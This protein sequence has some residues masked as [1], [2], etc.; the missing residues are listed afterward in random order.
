MQR[1]KNAAGIQNSYVAKMQQKLVGPNI[2]VL[3][4]LKAAAGG[5]RLEPGREFLNKRDK[6]EFDG[7]SSSLEIAATH[8]SSSPEAACYTIFQRHAT[9]CA[10]RCAT[11][12]ATQRATRSL[13]S[14]QQHFPS[15]QMFPQ[16]LPT[17]TNK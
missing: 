6:G 12:S 15:S 5:R 14:V 16:L 1:A 11:Q 8:E 9:Q 17:S 4:Q 3:L 13:N 7:H 2:E 10:T